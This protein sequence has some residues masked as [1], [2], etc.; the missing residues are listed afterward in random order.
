MTYLITEIL[1]HHERMA[2]KRLLTGEVA[3][4]FLINNSRINIIIAIR[5]GHS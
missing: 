5:T 1:C 3:Y 4:I 2:I